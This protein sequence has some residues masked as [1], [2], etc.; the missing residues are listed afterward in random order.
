MNIVS[1]RSKNLSHI[2]FSVDK[3]SVVHVNDNDF[4]TEHQVN[5]DETLSSTSTFFSGTMV[6]SLSSAP[7]SVTSKKIPDKT[8]TICSTGY[9]LNDWA[10]TA[11]KHFLVE[12]SISRRTRRRL[13]EFSPMKSMAGY[14]HRKS[15]TLYQSIYSQAESFID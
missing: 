6:K 10:S 11:I 2:I 7:I 12:N 4:S 13:L 9:E 8:R 15:S 14:F 5:I 3:F 1:Y